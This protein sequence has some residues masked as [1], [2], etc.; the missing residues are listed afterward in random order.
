LRKSLEISALERF[1]ALLSSTNYF[2]EQRNSCGA[3]LAK[4]LEEGK[5]ELTGRTFSG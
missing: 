1:D 5:K 2:P 3:P 4:V